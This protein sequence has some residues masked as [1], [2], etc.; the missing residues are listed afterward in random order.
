[1]GD[2]A[3]FENVGFEGERGE[4]CVKVGVRWEGIEMMDVIRTVERAVPQVVQ[5]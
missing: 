5:C 2:V 4:V 1:M 3:T